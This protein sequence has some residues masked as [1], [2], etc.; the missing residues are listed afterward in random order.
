MPKSWAFSAPERRRSLQVKHNCA[1]TDLEEVR[2]FSTSQE[3]RDKF[4][5]RIVELIGVKAVPVAH[6]REAVEGCD[7]VTTATN[8]NE[9]VFDGE[10]LR[11]GTH[12]NTMIG[13]DYFLPRRET[14]EKTVL[15]SDIIVVNSRASIRLDKQPELYPLLRRGVLDWS[16]IFEIGDLL[17]RRTYM[18]APPASR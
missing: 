13:S 1:V 3:R 7:I 5:R 15:K 16:D 11:P 12:V 9:P 4:A 18:A 6:P 14:D 17:V 2:V 8:S 10:W